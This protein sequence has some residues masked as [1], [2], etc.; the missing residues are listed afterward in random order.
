MPWRDTAC[1]RH[2]LRQGASAWNSTSGVGLFVGVFVGDGGLNELR[3]VFG[4]WSMVS[5]KRCR[6]AVR[7]EGGSEL[8]DVVFL[9]EEDGVRIAR[10]VN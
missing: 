5:V 8:R 2:K 9:P 10:D 7:R 6:D 3:Q 4:R 1:P